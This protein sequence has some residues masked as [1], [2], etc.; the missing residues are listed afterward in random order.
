MMCIMY[1]E[2]VQHRSTT[3]ICNNHVFYL[4][5]RLVNLHLLPLMTWPEF[6][7]IIFLFR[8]LRNPDQAEIGNYLSFVCSST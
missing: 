4:K 7:D 8:Y 5:S 2:M 1:L 6:Q 3:F